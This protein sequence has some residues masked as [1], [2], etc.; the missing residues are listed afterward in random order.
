MKVTVLGAA[1]GIGQPLSLLLK[2]NTSI[3]V[4]SLYDIVNAH[5]V[6]ADLSHIPTKSSVE[7]YQ[8]TSKTDTTQLQQALVGSDV[9]VIPA[10]IPRKPGMTRDDLFKINAGIVAGLVN[11]IS[12]HSPK[13]SVCI[14][15]NPVNSMVPLA[16]K[17]LKQNGVFDP[18]KLFG[19][20]TLDL[21]RFETFSAKL[22]GVSDPDLLKGRISVI[23]GHSGNTI[24]PLSHLSNNI[25][26][27]FQQ[28]V[29]EPKDLIH[30]VQFGGDEVVKAK[31]GRG[32]ATLS[33]A[34]AAY[35]FIQTIIDPSTR[36]SGIVPEST[37][38]SLRG[39]QGGDALADHLGVEFF[40]I[41]VQIGQNG[42]A[43][44]IV[45][46]FELDFVSSDEKKLV[47]IA[48]KELKG[49]IEKGLNFKYDAKL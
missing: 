44:R 34:A 20:T 25:S 43:E 14:I 32:S 38:V 5:G 37:F 10:G 17:I 15:S 7:S 1:G 29:P 31:E 33:M 6:A 18:R 35:R 46:P 12:I 23:G 26:T 22:L 2:L 45:D 40:A 48:V 4:L 3:D 11:A 16:A 19:V 9:V 36:H 21:Q 41:P 30:R 49:N 47:A 42:Q 13:A 24:V 27:K 28:F 39:I 8:P